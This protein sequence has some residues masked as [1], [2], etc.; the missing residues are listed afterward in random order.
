[1]FIKRDRGTGKCKWG[2]RDGGVTLE[3]RG[4]RK[5]FWRLREARTVK[6]EIHGLMTTD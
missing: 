2:P 3:I 6:G 1:M 5:F 4:G